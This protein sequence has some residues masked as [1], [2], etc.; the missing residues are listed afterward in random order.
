MSKN[1]DIF[2]LLLVLFFGYVGLNQ[3]LAIPDVVTATTTTIADQRTPT[4]L[5][6]INRTLTPGDVLTDD[7]ETICVSGYSS[8][9]RNVT[10]VMKRQVYKD[11]GK[12][13]G[14]DKYDVE[15]LV[16]LSIGG[17]NDYSNLWLIDDELHKNKT[18]LDRWLKTGIC[19]G[20]YN[21]TEIH[22]KVSNDWYSLYKEIEATK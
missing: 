19:N 13:Y 1:N 22:Q 15:H 3:D 8:T 10:T 12:T 6:F 20:E 16:A 11:Y 17:S 4:T 9:V 7:L 5:Y 18:R 14:V 2:Y 21:I